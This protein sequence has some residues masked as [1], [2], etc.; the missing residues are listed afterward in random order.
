MFD[1]VVVFLAIS[2]AAAYLVRSL[3]KRKLRKM[4]NF[5]CGGCYECTNSRVA[6]SNKLVYINGCL[7][8]ENGKD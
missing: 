7:G 4:E 5:A 2:G 6:G 1:T 3:V 8:K